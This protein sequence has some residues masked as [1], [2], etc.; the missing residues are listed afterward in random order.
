MVGA[1][2]GIDPPLASE[3]MRARPGKKAREQQ[4]EDGKCDPPNRRRSLPKFALPQHRIRDNYQQYAPAGTAVQFFGPF[5]V[6]FGQEKWR[7]PD[8]P[9]SSKDGVCVRWHAVFVTS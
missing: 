4:K 8:E 1:E 9:S 5:G 3:S 6:S 7:Q 2:A